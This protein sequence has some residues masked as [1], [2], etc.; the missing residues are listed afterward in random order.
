[1]HTHYLRIHLHLHLPIHIH[2]P[3]DHL[4]GLPQD[5]SAILH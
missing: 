2:I 5:A 4:R 3:S 1:M